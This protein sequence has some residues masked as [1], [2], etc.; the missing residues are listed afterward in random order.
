[1]VQVFYQ[2]TYRPYPPRRQ[3][4][5]PEEFYRA[6]LL[7]AEYWEA[8]LR[9]F[10]PVAL[11]Q[12][13]W[14]E[15]SKHSFV[16]E[17]MTRPGG[18]YPKYGVLDRLYAGSEHDG[19]PD[20]FTNAVYAN[21]E[22]G[23]FETAKSFIENYFDEF[24][25]SQGLVN[26]R[27]PETGQYGLMLSL[28]ARHLNYTRDNALLSKYQGKLRAIAGLLTELHDESLRLPREN[29]GQGLIHGW[30]EADS[31]LMSDPPRHWQPYFGNSALASRGFNDLGRA[32]L[33]I[34]RVAANPSLEKQGQELL[35]RSQT[36][37]EAIAVRLE[38]SIRRNLTPPYVG[39]LPGMAHTFDDDGRRDPQ[40]P[41]AFSTRSYIELLQADVLPPNL[42][43][44]VVDCMLAYNGTTLG[45]PGGW[46]DIQGKNR[47][48]LAFISYGYAQALLR[49]ERIEEFLLFL[50]AH[51]YHCHT[52]G[53]WTA[54]ETAGIAR[55]PDKA[56]PPYCT[57]AQQAIPLLVRWMLVLEDSDQDRVY[58]AKGLPRAWLI[59]GK[60]ISIQQAPTRWGRINFSLRAKP[61]TKVIVA[62]V[63]LPSPGAPKEFH[64]KLRLPAGHPAETVTVNGRTGD[65]SGP[66]R[67]TVIVETR[68]EKSFE[69]VAHFR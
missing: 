20:T 55:A 12:N 17:L 2:H 53:H 37:R 36:L 31:C 18:V 34:A 54:A 69:V 19:F 16:K 67:D 56:Q 39:P 35:V 65:F 23:R 27:G 7:F 3:N 38:S 21:L 47:H 33:E 59:S 50:Y 29:P 1:M 62:R 52:R 64:L 57:P 6:F 45:I 13:D 63:E 5:K 42:S 43:N 58:L 30:S 60:D 41:Q 9:D 44:L 8:Q 40:G 48:M 28:L 51:R 32:W 66:H 25:D 11:P 15:M 4:P 68:N 26:Y 14:V 24:V 10:V 22:W 46:R 61:E 49:L